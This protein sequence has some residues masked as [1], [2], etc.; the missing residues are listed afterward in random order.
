MQPMLS[1][2]QNVKW[3][4]SK[5]KKIEKKKFFYGRFRE[6]T[7]KLTRI[8]PRYPRHFTNNSLIVEHL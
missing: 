1:D 4:E 6:K 2:A 8:A 7:K 5:K 3:Y